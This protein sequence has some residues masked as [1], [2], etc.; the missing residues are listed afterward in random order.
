MIVHAGATIQTDAT[1]DTEERMYALSVA[2]EAEGR[3]TGARTGF[4]FVG[5]DNLV[6]P[7]PRKRRGSIRSFVVRPRSNARRE[8]A[9]RN[10]PFPYY[11]GGCDEMDR[12]ADMESSPFSSQPEAPYG[13]KAV[14]PTAERRADLGA[15]LG[16]TVTRV[17]NRL[18]RSNVWARSRPTFG[19]LCSRRARGV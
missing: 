16:S 9:F 17:R 19:T 12:T 13:H 3:W 10:Y 6:E 7:K 11:E 14:G 1:I 8:A 2:C 15:L 18:K 5:S 4:R